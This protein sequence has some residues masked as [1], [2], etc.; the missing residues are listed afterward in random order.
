MQ[1]ININRNMAKKQTVFDKVY[2]NILLEMN[3]NKSDVINEELLDAQGK[4]YVGMVNSTEE[5]PDGSSGFCIH[6]PQI[7]SFA[8]E[9]DVNMAILIS[10]VF[11]SIQ[12]QWTDV[13]FSFDDF[14]QWVL[15]TDKKSQSSPKTTDWRYESSA[16]F[17]SMINRIGPGAV[18]IKEL[19][20]NKTKTYNDIMEI[21]DSNKGRT[22]EEKLNTSIKVWYRLQQVTGLGPTK[23]AFAVQLMLGQL[24]CIDSINSVVY[25]SLAPDSLFTKKTNKEGDLTLSMKTATK[26]PKTKELN[27]T[28]KKVAEGYLQF[29]KSLENAMKI[30]ISKN[31]WD[32]WCDIVAFKIQHSTN[33][34]ERGSIGVVL[35]DKSIADTLPY[36]VSVKNK[37]Q[38]DKYK[39]MLG[40]PTG[41]DVSR[42]HSEIITGVRNRIG[43]NLNMAKK[44]TAFDTVYNNILL[45]MGF[46]A[47]AKDR[48]I[49]NLSGVQSQGA[50][51]A[52]AGVNAKPN[53]GTQKKFAGNPKFSPQIPGAG[54]QPAAAGAM[55]QQ[56]I[57]SAVAQQEKKF[58]DLLAM[59][60]KNP[61][62]FQ[63]EYQEKIAKDPKRNAEFLAY[64]IQQP[65][66]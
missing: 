44:Q 57:N 32:V 23:A 59:H 24:G 61:A 2:N 49:G 31:L 27:K 54:I 28:G 4:P 64:L 33:R 7:K 60:E 34:S 56:G 37:K 13:K 36:G 12:K 66:K 39:E 41:F 15:T 17:S 51:M 46:L 16:S 19:W 58:A 20:K 38:I 1:E 11:F 26:D 10:F 25:Q 50:G 3:S 47:N 45:E 22:P 65:V 62:Q 30:D 48:G 55:Q 6:Q 53:T 52:P 21:I 43:E 35:P 14:I 9:N 63:K 18:Y 29:L 40:I 8:L 5:K 42:D